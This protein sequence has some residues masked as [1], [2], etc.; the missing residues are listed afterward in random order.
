MKNIIAALIFVFSLQSSAQ[1][2]TDLINQVSLDKLTLTLNEFSG[3]VPTTVNGNTVTIINREQANNDLAADYLKEQLQKLN[4]VTVTD[5]AFNVNGR[6]IFATQ[7]GKTNPNDIYIICAHY[8]SVDNY[9]ADDN[10]SGTGAVLEIAR[11]LSTQCTDNTIIYALWDEEESGLLGAQHYATLANVNGDNILGVLNMD[12]MAH[13]DINPNDNDFDIDV[14]PIA[15]SIAMKD[16]LV[17]LLNTYSFN[18]TVNVVNP[19]T[20]DS[21]HSK[22]WDNGFSAVLV[23]ESWETGDQTQHYHSAG[24][25]VSTLDL[26]YYHE[27]TKLVMAYTA[28]KAGLINI[29]NT[30]TQNGASLV[31]NQT[32]VTYKWID[33]N[34]NTEIPGEVNQTFTATAN[35]NYKVEINSGSCTETS[36]CYAIST[37]SVESFNAEDFKI[38]PN[39]VKTILN[40]ELPQF[41]KAELSILNINGQVVLEQAIEETSTKLKLSTLNNGIYFLTLKIDGKEINQKIIKE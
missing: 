37:L 25:R 38:F 26:P 35:G 14:Q 27:I 32:G 19:G 21:D 5:Q 36:E 2:I 28:T 10:V 3:E 23:G 12:M 11:I 34:T 13:N 39:P 41:N 18:L 9:C 7:L 17:S 8:D 6:N 31:A 40:I 4:N 33:C 29:E 30:V 16:D 20:P 22:F 15:N 1:T 24:D